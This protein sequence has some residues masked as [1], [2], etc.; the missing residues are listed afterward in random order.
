MFPHLIR[1]DDQHR[2]E[3]STEPSDRSDGELSSDSDDDEG[4]ECI[5]TIGQHRPIGQSE[6]PRTRAGSSLSIGR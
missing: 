1:D 2:N 3:Q 5:A 6:I 4:E